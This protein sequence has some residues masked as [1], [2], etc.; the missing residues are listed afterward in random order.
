MF[1]LDRFQEIWIT[2]TRNKVRSLLTGFGVFWG[3]F[4]LMIML[5]AG[6]GLERG[7]L[8]QVEGLATNSC[9]MGAST[10]SEP[11]QGF[12]RG[13]QWNI[14]N[15]DVDILAHSVPELDCLSPMLFGGRSTNNIVYN[16]NY[17]TF[18]IKGAYANYTQIERQTITYG[19][20]INEMDN[21][22]ERKVCVLGIK[23]YEDLFPTR[24]NP[25]GRYVR[26]W[27]IY[28][29]VVG[30]TSG[31]ST[32]SLN[33]RSD[34]SV[35]L[36]F[37]TLQKVI[38][39]G[40]IIHVL[41]ATAKPNVPVSRLE[42]KMKETLRANNSIAPTDEQA[43]WSF[44]M[45]NQFNIFKYLFLGIAIVVW[46]VGSG[47]LIA[48]II[49]VSN[50]MLVTVRERTKEIGIR[51]A[52]GAKP[53]TIIGQIMLESVVLTAIAGIL[54]LCFGVLCLHLAD[55]Y[56]LQNIENMF[57]SNLM[58]SFNTAVISTV[59]L[60]FFGLIAGSIPAVRAMQIKAIDAIQEE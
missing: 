6:H 58:V 4:M 45:E 11:Y 37:K 33:G 21:L 8:D 59:I 27:G 9:F 51:R 24:E 12:Q 1:D 50:I 56:W 57:I 44:N 28:F 42:A 29:Q 15:K 2:L 32:I 22:E 26:I 40:D 5:G 53:R 20:F 48:G 3:I 19:R 36:P 43:V 35:F 25:I 49:G 18:Q 39:Q 23:V 7:M 47:T 54:G 52:L 30:V 31:V 14:R 13:R 41:T 46:I 34:E 60:L 55:V 10:T 16:E 38:N 17:G